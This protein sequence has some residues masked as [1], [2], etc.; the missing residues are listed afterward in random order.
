MKGKE[1]RTSDKSVEA[2]T[3]ERLQQAWKESHDSLKQTAGEQVDKG[4]ASNA[5]RS[6]PSSSVEALTTERLQQAWKESHDSLK[7]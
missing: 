5:K 3:I 2:L 7:M 4:Q 1:M 6:G